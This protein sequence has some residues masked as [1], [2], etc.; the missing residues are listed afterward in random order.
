[1]NPDTGELYDSMKLALDAGEKPKDLV[2]I[3]GTKQQ[4]QEISEKIKSFNRM[5]IPR[6][7]KVNHAKSA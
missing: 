6:T 1:M 3:Y 5:D 7:R 2:E 4:A